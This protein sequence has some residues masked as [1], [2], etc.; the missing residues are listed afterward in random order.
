M[1]GLTSGESTLP[2]P[3]AA[4]SS[5]LATISARLAPRP[6]RHVRRVGL[7]VLLHVLLVVHHPGDRVEVDAVLRGQDAADPDAGGDRVGAHADLLSLEVPRR[8]HTRLHVVDDGGVVKLAQDEHGQRGEGLAV[9]LRRQVCGHGHLAHVELEPAAHPTE[10]P[11][12]RADLDVLQP[13]T[14]TLPSF[15]PFVCEYVAM[16][17]L[18]TVVAE[19]MA[20]SIRRR[21]SP[22]PRRRQGSRRPG[23]AP[24]SPRA[25][26]RL[27]AGSCRRS[28]SGRPPDCRHPAGRH[29][30]RGAPVR[31]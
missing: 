29:P 20:A 15:R 31:R 2:V 11:D 8:R 13:G 16:A 23:A 30:R 18:S 24:S 6:V 3:M 1:S 4:A 10:G 14:V 17:V 25:S 22:A 28:D 27:A 21:R 12:D 9:R 7:L 26:R 5:P 19:A